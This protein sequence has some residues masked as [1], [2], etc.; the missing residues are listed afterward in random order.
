MDAE[1]L[2]HYSHR[3]LDSHSGC[4]SAGLS[5]RDSELIPIFAKICVTIQDQSENLRHV[6]SLH[7]DQVMLRDHLVDQAIAGR[8]R[9]PQTREQGFLLFGDVRLEAVL[10]VFQK[11]PH[12]RANWA[13]VTLE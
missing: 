5:Q 11:P 1:L 6:S 9:R 12:L 7:S 13:G 2:G 4:L 10:Q 3:V 8:K